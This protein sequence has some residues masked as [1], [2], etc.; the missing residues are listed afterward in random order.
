M[1]FFLTT[2]PLAYSIKLFFFGFLR[3]QSCFCILSYHSCTVSSGIMPQLGG[4]TWGCTFSISRGMITASR[5]GI[6]LCV[7]IASQRWLSLEWRHSFHI[8]S[9]LLMLKK[10]KNGLITLVF[11]LS[12]GR[13][14]AH[15]RYLSLRTPANH[16]LCVSTRNHAKSVLR[17]TNNSYVNG[18]CQILA[19]SNFPVVLTPCQKYLQHFTSSAFPSLLLP[20]ST[21][22]VSA[23]FKAELLSNL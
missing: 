11:R 7:F 1:T 9:L 18:Q 15:K 12:K 16:N 17:F 10:K 2:N 13:E 20:D 8:L 3:S 5:T 4:M 19:S 21:T 6:P 23:V 14:A 22:A